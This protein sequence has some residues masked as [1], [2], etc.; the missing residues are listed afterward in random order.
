MSSD[1]HFER[2]K[3][4]SMGVDFTK[5]T[6]PTREELN[7]VS[8]VKSS[9]PLGISVVNNKNGRR[10]KL[11]NALFEFLGNPKRLKFIRDGEYLILGENLPH[12]TESVAFSKGKG[13]TI[14]YDV[15]FV[16]YVTEQFNL[17]YS[18]RTSYSFHDVEVGTQEHEGDVITYAK[19]KM[20]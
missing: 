17:D 7:K 18:E 9:G 6:P 12:C 4:V 11:T 5:L 10:V 8:A 16:W 2:A 19:I 13:T 3:T 14:I 1:M 15:Q 20:N